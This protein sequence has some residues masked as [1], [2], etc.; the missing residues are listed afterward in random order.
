MSW[1][2]Q[3][4][5]G[6]RELIG[7]SE[8]VVELPPGTTA[9]DLKKYVEL[10]YTALSGRMGAVRVAARFDFLE[11]SEALP[12]GEDLALIPPV[13]GGSPATETS[14]RIRLSSEVLE[15]AR[16]LDL[17]RGPDAGGIA[18]FIGT[19]RSV[20]RGR[21]VLHLEYEAF[22]GMA[23]D[24]MRRIAEAAV[25]EFGC[26]RIAVFHRTGRV[27][28]GEDAVVIAAAAAHRDQ[29]LR[30]CRAVIEALKA[31]VPIWKREFYEEGSSWVG[32]GS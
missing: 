8:L 26:L 29:A 17:V 20:S 1:R 12:E 19:V 9:G 28:V 18:S 2:V 16:V 10:E 13:S 27:K 32:W 31:D 6:L 23:L 25:Q 5:A 11:D 3:C 24:R 30:A 22:S 21:T 14:D 15:P 4:F 7:Q